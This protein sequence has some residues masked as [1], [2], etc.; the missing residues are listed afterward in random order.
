MKNIINRTDKIVLPDCMYRV[1]NLIDFTNEDD[2]NI[3]DQVDKF[4]KVYN[5]F[6]FESILQNSPSP[7]EWQMDI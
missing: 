6:Y 4:L 2:I 3:G 5:I 7:K 1:K